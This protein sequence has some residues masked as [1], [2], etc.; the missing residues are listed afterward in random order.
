MR[1]IL[2]FFFHLNELMSKAQDSAKKPKVWLALS[3]GGS[4][5]GS[6]ACGGLHYLEPKVEIERITSVSGGGYAA[7][8]FVVCKA[9]RKIWI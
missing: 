8:S 3:G 6:F 4:R 5:S 2:D 7:G 1:W 9:Q